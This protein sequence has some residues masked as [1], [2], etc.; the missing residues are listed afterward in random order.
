MSGRSRRPYLLGILGAVL[1]VGGGRPQ[2]AFAQVTSTPIVAPAS[3]SAAATESA[4]PQPFPGDLGWMNGTNSNPPST[5]TAGPIAVSMLLDTYYSYSFNHPADHTIFP[6]ISAPRHNEFNLNLGYI[7]ME[8]TG[9]PNTIGKFVVQGG[10]EVDM[11]NGVDPT[12]NPPTARG[13]FSSINSLRYVREAFVGYHFDV[14]YGFNL[15]AGIFPAYVGME[16]YEPQENWN[17][18][19]NLVCDFTPYYLQGISAQLFPLQTLKTELWFF[20]GWQTMAKLTDA[21]GYGYV[22]EWH[23]TDHFSLRQN[24][25][26]GNVNLGDP[27]RLR[28]Y[29]DQGLQWKYGENCFGTKYCALA[30]IFDA[31]YE[32]AGT[33]GA[34]PATMLGAALL[35][36]TQLTDQWSTT[37][38]VS[39]YD[40]PQHLVALTPPAGTLANGD[41]QAGE[42]T[43]GVDYKVNP[44]LT[45]R[46]E[47]RHDFSRNVPYIAGPGGITPPSPSTIG[48]TPDLRY[49][50][51]RITLN[52]TL[53]F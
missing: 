9:I 42:A 46:L 20:N 7:G 43:V 18:T 2:E 39:Y 38:R 53:R 37:E 12:I 21:F 25:L 13:A 11:V 34:T 35:H 51:D 14:L 22:V 50:G 10:N 23:P 3:G 45:Y 44:W 1:L 41:L 5:A 27:S 33:N 29:M 8:L 40:D 49:S 36:R 17:Y 19:H 48:F 52:S 47:Y 4:P 32:T 24:F 26:T 6:T 31:G 15:T 28:I 16:S 30:A